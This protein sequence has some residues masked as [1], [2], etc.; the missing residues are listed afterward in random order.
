MTRDYTRYESMD[1]A[2]LYDIC[3]DAWGAVEVEYIAMRQQAV[4][5]EERQVWSD[6]IARGNKHFHNL[7]L[8]ERP[9]ILAAMQAWDTEK[10]RIRTARVA[11]DTSV[12]PLL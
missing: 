8:V 6:A 9:E 3:K 11:S 2:M 10:L 5:T 12:G 4:N 7:I 1:D